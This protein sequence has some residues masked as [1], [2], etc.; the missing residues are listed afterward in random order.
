M[1][2]LGINLYHMMDHRLRQQFLLLR[3]MSLIIAY[4]P[5][6]LVMSGLRQQHYLICLIVI[7]IITAVSNGANITD[8]I[9]GLATG[10]SAIIGAFWVCLLKSGN[11]ILASY[12]NVM[13]IPESGS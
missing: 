6:G 12:L 13:Y 8:G 2:L 1:I 5:A 10:T 3:I 7:L 9:D 4:L 11:I